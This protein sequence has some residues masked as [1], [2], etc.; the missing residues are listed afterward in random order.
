MNIWK[1]R[2]AVTK[3]E[4]SLSRFHL[5]GSPRRSEC[6]PILR[7]TK[8][9][10]EETII[11]EKTLS[12]AWRWLDYTNDGSHIQRIVCII[13]PAPSQIL[14]PSACLNMKPL[15]LHLAGRLLYSPSLSAIMTS[16]ALFPSRDFFIIGIY[17]LT[18]QYIQTNI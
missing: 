13:Q 16:Q 6:I 12:E 2:S 9:T 1:R 7:S 14:H 11:E 15:T 18:K 5:S 10:N 8:S 4:I 17:I 3:V